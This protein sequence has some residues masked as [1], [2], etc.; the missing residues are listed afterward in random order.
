MDY[1]EKLESATCKS[2][3]LL[4]MWIG[5][6]G[7]V[8]KNSEEKIM[9]I[10]VY[11]SDLAMRQD[12]NKRLTPALVAAE[13]LE[14]NVILASHSHTDHLDLDSLPAMLSMK[15]KLFCSS[16]CYELCQESGLPMEKIQEIKVKDCFEEQGYQVDVV[17]ADHG[18]TS[19]DAVGFLIKTEGINVYFTGDT[20]YQYERM[21]AAIE[22]GV[23]ILLAPINGEYGNM[24]ES[25]VAMLAMQSNA[26]L[27]VPCH[28]WTFARHQGS[29]YQFEAA[30]KMIAPGQETC[31]MAHGEIIRY[32]RDGSWE[33]I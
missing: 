14:T 31:V 3:E 6:A 8:L 5:Q 1:I 28:F 12:G 17:Y 16:K 15:T 22:K 29:P 27:T 21:K 20:S 7:F 9:A 33:T 2:G 25:D 13:Q 11:L 23:D 30:M 32:G 4:V 10:D 18:D 26:K 24:N 19:P